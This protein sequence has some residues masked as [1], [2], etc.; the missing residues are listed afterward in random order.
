MVVYELPDAWIFTSSIITSPLL[1]IFQAR[2]LIQSLGAIPSAKINRSLLLISAPTLGVHMEALHGNSER[3][4]PPCA[5]RTPL[6]IP[7]VAAVLIPTVATCS[8]AGR[9]PLGLTGLELGI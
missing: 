4:V 3:R 1:S 9:K 6:P 2:L 8:L 5:R 7:Q